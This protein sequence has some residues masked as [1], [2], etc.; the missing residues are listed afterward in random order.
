MT[1]KRTFTTRT[2]K[3]T[4]TAFA[5]RGSHGTHHGRRSVVPGLGSF[6]SHNPSPANHN[7]LAKRKFIKKRIHLDLHLIFWP[8]FVPVS[9]C[10]CSMWVAGCCLKLS[11][12]SS[13]PTTSAARRERQL[14]PNTEQIQHYLPLRFELLRDRTLHSLFKCDSSWKNSPC[15]NAL[16]RILQQNFCSVALQVGIFNKHNSFSIKIFHLDSFWSENGLKPRVE[17]VGLI[18]TRDSLTE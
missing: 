7:T 1:L 16:L 11:Q 17:L 15:S 5:T 6:S 9:C 14:A 18:A 3:R 2:T 13:E 10:S 12:P 4:L 8:S